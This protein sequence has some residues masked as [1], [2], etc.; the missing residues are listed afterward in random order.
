ML[1]SMLEA[2]VSLLAVGI[3]VW[4]LY[5]ANLRRAEIVL[6]NIDLPDSHQPVL[7]RSFL[8]WNAEAQIYFAA[9]NNGARGGILDPIVWIE[10]EG[11]P[12]LIKW[13]QE[14]S[15]LLDIVSRHPNLRALE[16]G[17]MI[18]LILKLA[19]TWDTEE[20]SNPPQP[21]DQKLEEAF[22][23]TVPKT[24]SIEAV[25]TYRY[26]TQPPLLIGLLPWKRRQVHKENTVTCTIPL[27]P[28][29]ARLAELIAQES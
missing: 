9:Y 19:L 17:D 11:P 7:S 4:A 26:L 12:G 15:N 21:A 14:R 1:S 3:A 20:G 25:V 24:G 2:F 13:S 10:T 8:H 28:L 18:V 29:H 23:R 6:F 22:L 16:A 5:I 27:E